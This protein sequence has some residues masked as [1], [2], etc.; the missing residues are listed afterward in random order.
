MK[1]ADLTRIV[2][3]KGVRVRLLYS[4]G[5]DT[6]EKVAIQDP[7]TL[8]ELTIKVNEAEKLMKRHPTLV[9]TTYWIRQAKELEPIID[10]N[11]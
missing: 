10:W 5:V 1:I 9:E 6:V 8:R 11:N 2:D 7:E 4:T 3:I